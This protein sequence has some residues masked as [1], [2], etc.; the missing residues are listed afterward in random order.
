MREAGFACF[1][2]NR[3][4]C[5][6]ARRPCFSCGARASRLPPGRSEGRQ[7]SRELTTRGCVRAVS[8]YPLL[9]CALTAVYKAKVRPIEEAYK[10]GAFFSPLLTDADFDGKPQARDEAVC[11]AAP[12]A[13]GSDGWRCGGVPMAP[14]A[15]ARWSEP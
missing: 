2:G 5:P 6:A 10:F 1:W 15:A 13:L 4:L 11:C 3:A 9:F 12:A 7:G 14:A 8:M